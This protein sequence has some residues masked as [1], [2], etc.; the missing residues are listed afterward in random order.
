MN[1]HRLAALGILLASSAL[2]GCVPAAQVV[3]SAALS[4][5]WSEIKDHQDSDSDAAPKPVKVAAAKKAAPAIKIDAPPLQ[6]GSEWHYDD[7]YGMQVDGVSGN[8][9]RYRRTDDPTQWIVRR[10]FV[11]EDSQSA[12]SKR[13]MMFSDLG[14]DAGVEL[15][16]AAPLVYR[17][18]FR[19]NG[20]LHDQVTSWTIEGREHITVPAGAFDT[21][22]IVTRTRSQ[23]D[24]WTS[25]E[26]WY[27]APAVGN[28][29]RLEYQ[30]G[31]T[32]GSRVLMSY[33]LLGVD[34]AVMASAGPQDPFQSHFAD[35]A[36]GHDETNFVAADA[37]PIAPP[38]APHSAQ[39]KAASH[40]RNPMAV[41]AV[42]KPS[43]ADAMRALIAQLNQVPPSAAPATVAPSTVAPPTAAA[44]PPVTAPVIAAVPAAMQPPAPMP[45]TTLAPTVA[46]VPVLDE[47]SPSAPTAPVVAQS[48][49]EHP[50]HSRAVLVA[51][52]DD[53]RSLNEKQVAA[54][55]PMSV[56]TP[57]PDAVIAPAA[58]AIPAAVSAPAVAPAQDTASLP[59]AEAH[60]AH[61]KHPHPA[62]LGLYAP[63][64][65]R[66]GRVN[67]S[68]AG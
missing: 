51:T 40:P 48:H 37:P 34:G 52:A 7:N 17:R 61:A 28:Y 62:T 20:V 41:A 11:R 24:K 50:K 65:R 54:I 44:S 6:L 13:Q 26:R 21:Y 2:T 31:D 30:Y 3:G 67:Q 10:G 16:D 23:T 35:N 27:Y 5:I 29:V 49:R 53:T 15:T 4:A 63:D 55:M 42:A 56:A 39:A 45:A 66:V 18:E 9:T 38:I 60:Q 43:D 33:K 64:V 25:F 47:A 22:V 19:D 14:T 8:E 1:Y 32:A 59:Q 58:P 46:Q 57:A 36:S 12:T 68:Q